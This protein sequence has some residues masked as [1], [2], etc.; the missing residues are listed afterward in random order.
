M[1]LVLGLDLM[2]IFEKDCYWCE[3]PMPIMMMTAFEDPDGTE[4]L[5]YYCQGCV[6][7]KAAIS[8][9]AKGWK[10]VRPPVWLDNGASDAERRDNMCYRCRRLFTR[11]GTRRYYYSSTNVIRLCR[12]CRRVYFPWAVEARGPMDHARMSGAK[13]INQ[14]NKKTTQGVTNG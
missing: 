12:L 13:R 9:V 14:I 3:E 10:E 7:D 1:R 8:D 11:G 6:R 5:R 2:I 4:D